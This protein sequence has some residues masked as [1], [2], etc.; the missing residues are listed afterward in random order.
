M[1]AIPARGP[2]PCRCRTAEAS[3]ANAKLDK[4]IARHEKRSKAKPISAL[5]ASRTITAVMQSP[6]RG[7]PFK[8]YVWCCPATSKFNDPNHPFARIE[9]S[10]ENRLNDGQ[11]PKICA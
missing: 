2:N 9:L 8:H 10:D 6:F 5:S 11:F 4:A 7:V 1:I 3:T